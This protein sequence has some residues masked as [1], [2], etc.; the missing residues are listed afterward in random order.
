MAVAA[1]LAGGGAVYF[2]KQNLDTANFA[3]AIRLIQNDNRNY[4]CGTAAQSPVITDREG[5]SYCAVQMLNY[6]TPEEGGD[7]E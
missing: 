4:W 3:D 6:M 2:T 7:A 1:L 5:L